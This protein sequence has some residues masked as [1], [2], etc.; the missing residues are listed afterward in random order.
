M[1][2]LT[3][4]Q[5]DVSNE[6]TTVDV[7]CDVH[8]GAGKRQIRT[9][10]FITLCTFQ[11]KSTVIRFC[12]TISHSLQLCLDLFQLIFTQLGQMFL[13]ADEFDGKDSEKHTK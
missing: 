6:Q 7:R 4:Q 11:A 1:M 12:A 9:N 5:R 10:K 3:D 8:C 2:T 13:R